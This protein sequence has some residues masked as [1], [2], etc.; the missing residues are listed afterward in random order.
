MTFIQQEDHAN[1]ILVMLTFLWGATHGRGDRFPVVL[2]SETCNQAPFF[3]LIGAIM[4][5]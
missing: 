4:F 5:G 3:F 1:D 2:K